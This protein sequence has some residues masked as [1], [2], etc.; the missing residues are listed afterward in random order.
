VTTTSAVTE[1]SSQNNPDGGTLEITGNTSE[2][3]MIINDVTYVDFEL[4]TDGVGG[5][6][7]YTN[8]E[9]W[10]DILAS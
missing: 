5:A 6:D 9:L 3:T 8:D 2:L 4:D 1:N 10:A 7:V